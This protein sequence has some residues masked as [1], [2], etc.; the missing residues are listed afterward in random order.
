MMP[1][2]PRAGLTRMP[3]PI[4]PT[5]LAYMNHM[6]LTATQGTLGE[7]AAALLP[8]PWTYHEIGKRLGSIPHPIYAEWG[9]FYARGGLA[10]SV[11]AWT[12]LVDL[13]GATAGPVEREAMYRTFLTS[14]RYEY[15]FWEMVARRESW[16]V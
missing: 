2:P 1:V 15:C 14:S 8:C 7:T 11:K 3:V 13:T 10:D 9:A 16:P 12:E 4:A 6:L 5:N